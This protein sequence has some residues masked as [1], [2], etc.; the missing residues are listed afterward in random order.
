MKCSRKVFDDNILVL[1]NFVTTTNIQKVRYLYIPMVLLIFVMIFH[2]IVETSFGQTGPGLYNISGVLMS[3][4]KPIKISKAQQ[5][6]LN[7]EGLNNGYK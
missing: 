4:R 2:V 6:H 1:N 7:K 5:F 3:R